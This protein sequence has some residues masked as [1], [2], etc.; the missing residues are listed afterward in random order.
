MAEPVTVT[1][2]PAKEGDCLLLSYGRPLR[3]I[4]IDGGRA[5]TYRNALRP[6]FAAQGI[7]RLEL[8][9]VT[10]VDRDHVEG[11]LELCGDHTLPLQ[12]AHV[13]FNTWSH[14]NGEIPPPLASHANTSD[15]DEDLES[16]G[17]RMGEE[18]GPLLLD[19]S[20]PWNAQFSGG[21]VEIPDS[22]RRRITL[23]EAQLILLSPD[24]NKMTAL[25]PD[26]EKQCKKAGL[27]PGSTIEDYP[28]DDGEDIESFGTLNVDAL[29]AQNFSNDHSTANGSSIAFIFE[30]GGKR[31]LC[32][33]DAHEDLLCRQLRALGATPQ[34]PLALDAFKIP[35]H[36]SRY[37]LSRE[38]LELLHCQH[39][40][41]STNGNYFKHPDDVAIARLAKFGTPNAT[42]HFNYLTA[43]NRHWDNPEW[44]RNY[45]YRVAYP[46]PENDGYEVLHLG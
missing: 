14:L 19:R 44:M 38:L 42:I 41:V 3:H 24:R 35:H 25:L 16:F 10:H 39:Y 43:H 33:G 21:P 7:D 37:N 23:G 1:M 46:R 15:Q 5:W 27:Q 40:L 4:L 12:V 36:G 6:Y 11:M 26:W 22:G 17:A 31:I 32:A 13:W 18:L 45:Q 8:L 34:Q 29:A 20:W 28:A 30:F 9:V 2:L